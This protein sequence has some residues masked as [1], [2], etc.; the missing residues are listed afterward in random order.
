MVDE[1]VDL[2]KNLFSQKPCRGTNQKSEFVEI[3][4][5]LLLS[6]WYEIKIEWFVQALT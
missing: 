4:D 2:G 1:H 5:Y 6:K 3:N